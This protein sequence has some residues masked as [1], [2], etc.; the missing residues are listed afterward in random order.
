[1]VS[2]AHKG[3]DQS[4]SYS[5]RTNTKMVNMCSMRRLTGLMSTTGV[6]HIWLSLHSFPG[7]WRVWFGT[8]IFWCGDAGDPCVSSLKEAMHSTD[9]LLTDTCRDANKWKCESV[10]TTYW[11][12]TCDNGIVFSQWKPSVATSASISDSAFVYYHSK[13]LIVGIAD[14]SSTCPGFC[15]P[16]SV[17]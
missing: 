3:R 14:I 6:L 15:L 5:A 1:M 9:I 10:R 16:A 4:S 17:L 8:A 12:H 7:G 2:T 11:L 13:R